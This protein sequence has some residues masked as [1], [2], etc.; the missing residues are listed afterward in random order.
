MFVT[1]PCFER[2]VVGGTYRHNWATVIQ[3]RLWL[4]IH[5]PHAIIPAASDNG[6]DSRR[7]QETKELRQPDFVILGG[8]IAGLTFALEAT[9]RGKRV[10]VLESE[11][12]VGG[13]A[14]TLVF[15]DYRFDIGGHRYHSRWPE[16]TNWVLDVMNGDML[17]VPRRSRIRLDRKYVN[18]PLQFPSVL[19]ALGL[20]E[21]ARVL[22]SYLKASLWRNSGHQDV[23]FEDWVVRRFGRTLYDIYFRPYTEKVWGMDCNELS[24]DWASQRIKLPSLAAA[25]KGSLL[26]G[27]SPPGTLVSRFLYPP[28]GIG[29]IPERLAEKALATGWADIRLSSRVFRLESGD[30][31]NEWRVHYR[32]AGQEKT[33]CG[34]QVV[35]TIPL[36]SLLQ[37][38]PLADETAAALNSTLTYRGLTC[39]FLAIDGSCVSDDT[40]TYF[41]DPQLTFGRTHEPPNWS[42][43]MAPAGKTSLCA[44]VFCTQGDDVWQRPDGELIDAVTKDLDHLGFLVRGRVRDAW[45]LRVPDAYPV[46]RVGYADAVRR[47]RN[48]LARWPTLHL[49]GRTG[50]FQYLNMDGVIKQA[51]ELADVLIETT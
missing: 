47:V 49:L 18:Y 16:T 48:T 7:S 28:L 22:I 37:M 26:R 46:Y 39:V 30:T 27:T 50:S 29:M 4:T 8:G 40:W 10:V 13:L 11:D 42:S 33:V 14:R 2:H 15:G 21:A 20:P 23:S 24:A 5:L 35:S 32:Q 43:R 17:D 34:R 31:A 3:R 41:P 51:L 12:Q 38:L 44:E 19:T 25:V 45:V 6:D 1:A 36:G 9:R